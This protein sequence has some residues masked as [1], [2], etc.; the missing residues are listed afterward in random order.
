MRDL[1]T[2]LL[3]VD[4]VA[5]LLTVGFRVDVVYQITAT[6]HVRRNVSTTAMKSKNKSK[7]ENG[8]VFLRFTYILIVTCRYVIAVQILYFYEMQAAFLQ[9]VSI[10]CYAKRCIS[11]RKSVRLSVCPSVTRWHCVKT[12]QAT[13][14][15][16]SL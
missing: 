15:G 10:A 6:K 3:T 4:C 16:S 7:A 8:Y 14:T 11:Y 1:L 5:V 2:C 12:S 13:I 9:R